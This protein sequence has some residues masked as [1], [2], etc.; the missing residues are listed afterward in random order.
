MSRVRRARCRL[1]DRERSAR[2]V[3]GHL[4]TAEW[5]DRRTGDVGSANHLACG[6][7]LRAMARALEVIAFNVDV[8]LLVRAEPRQRE[9]RRRTGAHDRALLR[10]LHDDAG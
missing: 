10:D 7:E 4:E 9:E 6:G 2:L 3:D 5:S 1:F 8:A